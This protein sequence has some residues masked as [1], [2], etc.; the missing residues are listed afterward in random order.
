[1]RGRRAHHKTEHTMSLRILLSQDNEYETHACKRCYKQTWDF[2]LH[3]YFCIRTIVCIC[4]FWPFTI[5]NNIPSRIQS[6]LL[7]SPRL[8]HLSFW[9]F[10]RDFAILTAFWWC[11][12]IWCTNSGQQCWI[13]LGQQS[14]YAANWDRLFPVRCSS[15]T[16]FWRWPDWNRKAILCE[17]CVSGLQ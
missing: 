12:I 16:R 8:S 7:L 3:N 13:P 17:F 10:N 15:W 5:S 2:E 11:G 4:K 14:W 1:M 6:W 9:V